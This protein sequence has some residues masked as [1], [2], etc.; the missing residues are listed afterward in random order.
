MSSHN[1]LVGYP[2]NDTA[3]AVAHAEQAESDRE[4]P[5]RVWQCAICDQ[6]HAASW[7]GHGHHP[8]VTAAPLSTTT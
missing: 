7:I 4:T 6:W 8:E 5:Y 2:N 3:T 1:E